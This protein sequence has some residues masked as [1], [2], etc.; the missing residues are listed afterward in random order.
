VAA[1]NL[2]AEIGPDMA[3]V[4][5]AQQLASWAGVWPGNHESGEDF[6]GRRPRVLWHLS[7][8][9][10]P[11]PWLSKQQATESQ[12]FMSFFI[13]FGDGIDC[14]SA[15]GSPSSRRASASFQSAKKICAFRSGVRVLV[16]VRSLPVGENAGRLSNPS[17]YVTRTGGAWPSASIM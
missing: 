13:N 12:S 6:G 15:T 1:A 10:T 8:V 7:L 4:P 17:A 14:A 5:S 11:V 2:V 9:S 16:H 3:Q